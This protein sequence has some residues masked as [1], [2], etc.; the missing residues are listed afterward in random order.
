[1]YRLGPG[2]NSSA[3]LPKSEYWYL[4]EQQQFDSSLYDEDGFALGVPDDHPIRKIKAMLDQVMGVQKPL[5]V[6]KDLT[7]NLMML[8]Q[9]PTERLEVVEVKVVDPA[10][11]FGWDRLL[12]IDL[13][14]S[15]LPFPV[16]GGYFGSQNTFLSRIPQNGAPY[17]W[18]ASLDWHH[19]DS[20]P[21]LDNQVNFLL[22]NMA[23][24]ITEEIQRTCQH[25]WVVDLPP[26][27][28]TF[29]DDSVV[30]RFPPRPAVCHRCGAVVR[31][32]DVYTPP[33]IGPT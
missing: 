27:H 7:L 25:E 5:K 3:S 19:V 6:K 11:S 31:P 32:G 28:L 13:F 22:H 24:K 23:R 8:M 33:V 26:M 2:M 10:L 16:V 30:S 29:G 20:Q 15:L 1:M 12:Q 21:M 18:S 17:R 9:Y 4:G 14:V